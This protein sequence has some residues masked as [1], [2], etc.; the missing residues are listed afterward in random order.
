[1]LAIPVRANSSLARLVRE[2]HAYDS[3]RT[4]STEEKV[5]LLIVRDLLRLGW[6]MK[7]NSSSVEL[8][9]PSTYDKGVIWNSMQIRKQESLIKHKDW[10]GNHL[11]LVRQNL[12]DGP[13][14]WASKI[15][16]I[17]EVC[18]TQDQ[19]NL[20]RICRFY[21]SSPYSEY[22]G[23]RIKLLIRDNAI[24]SKPLI[25]IA[26]LGSSIIHIPDRDAWIGWNK[27]TRTQ[28][29]VYTMDAYVLGAMPPYN[30]LLG[31]KLVSYMITSREVREIYEQ[32][33]E[34]R[35][36]RISGRR[37]NRL[38]CIFTTGLYGRSSQYNR[39]RFNNSLLF[40]PVGQTKGYGTLHL[41][42][43]TFDAMRDLLES[44]KI[45]V[46]NRF[47]DGPIWRMRVIR[48]AADILGFDADVLLKHS[49]RRQVYAIPLAHNVREFLRGEHSKLR[50]HNYS[51]KELVPYWR[52]RWLSARKKNN[53]V[54]DSVNRFKAAALAIQ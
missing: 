47:G 49:F 8:R 38:A 54:S 6:E 31:G 7:L 27:A 3:I 14:V 1:M 11:D 12:G 36:T 29:L 16:P 28:N 53:Q 34:D 33:Y 51:L 4:R 42:D 50:Y 45:H 23:R 9:P 25:G 52:E 43:E 44:R 19:L 18:K 40:I 17:I 15:E 30:Y 24:A 26:A 48:T 13:D 32:K 20:F 2:D 5:R 10:I 39:V 37:A 41:T 21:W 35:I 22:V 46:N